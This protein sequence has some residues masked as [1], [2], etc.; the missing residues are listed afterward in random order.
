MNERKIQHY[1]DQ[2]RND[3]TSSPIAAWKTLSQASEAA[4]ATSQERQR[5]RSS[6]QA[7]ISYA[8]ATWKSVT[9]ALPVKSTPDNGRIFFVNARV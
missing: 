5:A 7:S 8:I 2:H 6:F 1:V 9:Q 4:K 3:T